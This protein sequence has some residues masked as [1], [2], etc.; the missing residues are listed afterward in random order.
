MKEIEE[1]ENAILDV[2]AC[3]ARLKRRR[4]DLSGSPKKG[5]TSREIDHHSAHSFNQANIDRLDD[6]IRHGNQ[7]IKRLKKELNKS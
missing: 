6:A 2:K 3:K 1:I 4:F 7:K 5:Y